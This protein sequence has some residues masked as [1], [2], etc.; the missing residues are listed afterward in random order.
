MLDVLIFAPH[1]DDAELAAGGTIVK[2]VKQDFKVGIIDLTAGEMGTHGTKEQRLKEAQTAKKVLGIN[3]RENLALPDGRLPFL[4]DEQPAFTLADK[5]REFQPKIVLLPYWVDRHP[6]HVATSHLV[7]QAL[8]FAKLTKIS[9][10]FPAHKINLAVYYELNG[11]F[12]PSFFVDISEEFEVKK[13]AIMSHKSQF[14]AFTREFLPFPV[15]ERCRYYGALINVAYAEAFLT[16]QP[17]QLSNWKLLLK[18][19]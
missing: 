13:K 8:H 3:L 18:S 4:K 14:K 2:L 9:L 7:Q 17:L 10:T 15:E 12:T 16:Q 5:I 11:S 6:D 19:D 1:P